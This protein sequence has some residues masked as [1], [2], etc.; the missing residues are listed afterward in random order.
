MKRRQRQL[1]GYTLVVIAFGGAGWL[2]FERVT[3]APARAAA[4]LQRG[5]TNMQ[6]GNY[7]GAVDHLSRSIDL[8]PSLAAA[9]LNR[10]IA[11]HA[12]G[13]RETA[14]EDLNQALSLDENLTRAYDERGRI[15]LEKK[16]SQRALNDFSK[17]VAIRPTTDGY[18]QRGLLYE[19]LGEHA[20]AVA[21]YDRAIDE[22]PDAPYAYR[23]R[24]L[25][26]AGLGDAKG[27][28]EDR[29]FADRMEGI[30]RAGQ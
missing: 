1:I 25:A 3:G 8:S 13:E 20:K 24:A 5:I 6:P 10:G 22:T 12:L 19:S 27:A 2:I 28:R 9:Y 16:D 29:D 21:D 30:R 14:L 7:E 11:L 23:A 26:K 18:Y 17:S 15:F 4:E